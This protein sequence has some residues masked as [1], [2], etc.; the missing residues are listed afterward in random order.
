MEGCKAL[1]GNG[2]DVKMEDADSS[3][4]ELR[5]VGGPPRAAGC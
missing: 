1:Q 2:V 3:A 5:A 4:S